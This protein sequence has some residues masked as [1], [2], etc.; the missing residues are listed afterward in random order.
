MKKFLGVIA[1]V[2]A[3]AVLGA[4]VSYG[5]DN[6]GIRSGEFFTERLDGGD[7]GMRITSYIGSSPDVHI[8]SYIRGRP[9]RV[10]GDGA[11]GGRFG[12]LGEEGRIAEIVAE[13]FG[14]VPIGRNFDGSSIYRT[15]LTSV[16]IPDSVAVIGQNAFSRNQL[17]AI[18]IPENV[19]RINR[20]AFAWNPITAVT[21]PDNVYRIGSYAFWSN[22]LTA[23]TIP[24]N[25]FYIGRGA[26]GNNP[27]VSITFS[28]NIHTVHQDVFSGSLRTVSQISIGAN[29]NLHYDGDYRDVIWDAFREAYAENGHRAGIFTRNEAGGWDWQPR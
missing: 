5:H 10:I 11:F 3:A 4:C 26:F 27:L 23:I 29:V 21:I 24:D 13:V 28:D 18:A 12:D 7:R 17:T 20:G 6:V 9:V 2:L 1:L 25:V 15:V 22:L 19:I 8:P 14:G 16:T